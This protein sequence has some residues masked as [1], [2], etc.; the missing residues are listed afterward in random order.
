MKKILFCL[1]ILVSSYFIIVYNIQ[2]NTQLYFSL[3]QHI[4]K[5]LKKQIRSTF[6]K[7]NTLYVYNSSS[8]A[9][10]EKR[11]IKLDSLKDNKMMK[12]YTNSNLIW[13]GPRAYFASDLENLFLITGTGI[14]MHVNKNDV[15]LNSNKIKF[16]TI[17]TNLDSILK[18]YKEN[19]FFYSY[20]SMIKSILY[21]NKNLYISLV[22][23]INKNCYTHII[24]KGTA[25]T[26]KIEFNEF[27][28]FE[29]CKPFYT[30]Y[31]GGSLADYKK[32]KILI[33]IG[34]WTICEDYRWVDN[35][36]K[37]FCTENGAQSLKTEFG[38]IFEL[39][40][41]TKDLKLI[42]IGH[43][44]PQGILFSESDNAIISTEHGPKGGDEININKSPSNKKV[45][46]FGYPISSY[47][48]HYGYPSPDVE[49]LYV[50]AP[51]YKSH[52]DYGFEEP[53]D[54][55]VPSIGISDVIKHKNKLFVASMGA[56]I[57]QG[58][59]SLYVYSID[60]NLNLSNKKI[61][62]IFQR[63]RDIHIFNDNVFL[64][65]ESTGSIGIFPINNI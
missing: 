2:N 9:F 48:E 18:N 14:L 46:N 19:K 63:I 27:Y 12:V 54:Y 22:Q 23:K 33:T 25:N 24:Y 16:N 56:E 37:G 55:F 51:L 57:E 44:N 5:N 17:D 41:N 34:D 26:K 15:N 45:K 36:P 13:T 58:D 32:D 1:I 4:P 21:K 52:K 64:F 39:N 3:K 47:G 31:L 60:K 7:I 35:N 42:S 61:N 53:V 28:K 20:T 59:L 29:R 40:L 62:K 11:G 49:Y 38:K 6:T 50:E 43:D 30:D 8:F 10:K 65:L